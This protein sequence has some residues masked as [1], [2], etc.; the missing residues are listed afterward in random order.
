MYSIC[1][2]QSEL[3]HL[4]L[5]LLMVKGATSFEDLRTVDNKICDTFH[6]ACLELD[7]IEDNGEWERA[8][9]DGEIWMMPRQLR[10]LFASILILFYPN[11]QGELWEMF[12]DLLTQ[13][14]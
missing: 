5:L 13:D 12:K 6:G 10:C 7:L 9:T 2:S 14:F 3:F 8:M 4:R 11:S 1:P